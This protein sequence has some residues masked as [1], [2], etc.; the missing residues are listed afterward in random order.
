MKILTICLFFFATNS[1]SKEVAVEVKGV[2]SG[3]EIELMVTNTGGEIVYLPDP[4]YYNA[5]IEFQSKNNNFT[6]TS[7]DL[8]VTQPFWKNLILLVPPREEPA[9][10][11]YHK[12][13]VKSDKEI[14]INM[15]SIFI[16]LWVASEPSFSKKN[17]TSFEL[18]KFPVIYSYKIPDK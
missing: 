1:Y 18:K 7:G 13:T 17:I 2:I 10:Y 11:G 14:N 15:D 9:N 3:K 5:L 12:F 4:N 8:K 6:L 16:S